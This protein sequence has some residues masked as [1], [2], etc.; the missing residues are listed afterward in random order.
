MAAVAAAGGTS[1]V[2][3]STSAVSSPRGFNEY[4]WSGA[5]S[6]CAST[7]PKPNW[8]SD[9][10]CKQRAY[11][12]LSASA[13]PGTGMQVYD[14]DAGGWIVSGGTSEASA[15][16]AAYYALAGSAAQGPSWAYVKASLLN[17]PASGS[18]GTCTITYLCTAGPGYDGPTG[19]GSISGAV[20]TGAPG[21]G[22]P[23][24]NGSYAVST[25]DHT[26]HLRG[27]IYPNGADTTYWWE[28]GTTTA[29][30]Q[31]TAPRDIGSGNQPVPVSDTLGTLPAGT[32]Y[33]YRLAAANSFGTEYGYDYTLTTAADPTTT[34]TTSTTP[35]PPTPPPIAQPPSGSPATIV[36]P[37]AV[38]TP[39]VIGAWASSAT[40]STT[41]A[42]GGVVASYSLQYGTTPAVSQRL[43]G[44]LA[45]ASAGLRLTIRGLAPGRSYYVRVVVGNA[46]G[47]APSATIR[48]RTSPV[49]IT[50]LAIQ[51]GHLQAVLRC[52]TRAP[53]RVRLQAQAQSRLIAARVVTI[54][55]NRSA[56][57]ALTLRRAFLAS[58]SK[59]HG[60]RPAVT[61]S[62]LS[63]WNGY[64]ATVM[65]TV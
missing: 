41:L 64:P 47:W 53:C 26:A 19:V 43:A 35:P 55:A 65:K 33:H 30:G 39:R 6:G 49:T 14:S 59:S 62:A 44:S 37:P 18:N 42:T 25:T 63:T 23:G 13:N 10:G 16:I 7:V 52:Y 28:Y 8:Q 57:V 9:T 38:G 22:G 27:G 45:A 3:A 17:D 46:A 50:G 20:A 1:L 36:A 24:P 15:L 5:G 60:H 29:Y 48:F 11:A 61:L 32:T 31:T 34:S 2:P 12:D 56:S 4:A 21:I 58:I 54:A 51:H 40:I